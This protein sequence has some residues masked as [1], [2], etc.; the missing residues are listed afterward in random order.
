[1]RR[2]ISHARSPP[3]SA[4]RCISAWLSQTKWRLNSI[5]WPFLV[6]DPKPPRVIQAIDAHFHNGHWQTALG[7]LA[8]AF[9]MRRIAPHLEVD[10][11]K[12]S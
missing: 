6:T 11:G 12:L 10:R 5:R 7:T 4:G 1:L 2:V 8:K 9:K 3:C